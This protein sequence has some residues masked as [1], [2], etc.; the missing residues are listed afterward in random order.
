MICEMC[1]KKANESDSLCDDC[2]YEIELRMSEEDIP[3]TMTHVDW[4]TYRMEMG[5]TE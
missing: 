3:V 1:N 5:F 4:Y 2:R